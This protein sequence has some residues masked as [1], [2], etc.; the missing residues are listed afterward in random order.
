MSD[1]HEIAALYGV[2]IA[3]GHVFNDANKRT[4]FVSM[5]TFLDLNGFDL[6]AA[7]SEIVDTMVEV[8]ENRLDVSELAQWL[9]ARTL[10]NT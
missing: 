10:P 2:A 1:L 7:S 8:A 3:Q 6:V 5:A 4:A 9:R